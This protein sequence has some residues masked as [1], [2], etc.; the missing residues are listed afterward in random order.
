MTALLFNLT[1]V[2]EDEAE[3]IRQLLASHNLEFYETD[4]G[5]WKSGVAAIW[6]HDPT[7]LEQARAL[8][9]EYQAQRQAQARSH[10]AELKAR[11]ELPSWSTKFRDNPWHF[12]AAVLFTGVATAVILALM[13]LPFLG[14]LAG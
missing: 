8:L 3:E 11:G 7:Q 5:R 2:P 6:L 4:A 14:Y 12:G 1:H 13:I 10:Y 9:N